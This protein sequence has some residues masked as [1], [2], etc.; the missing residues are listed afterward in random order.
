MG[1]TDPFLVFRTT[2]F[3][4]VAVYTVLTTTGTIWRLV[5]VLRGDDPRKRLLRTYLGYQLATVR[6]RP[7]SGELVQ[8]GIWV[9]VLAV[10]WYLHR[11]V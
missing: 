11:L 4:G 10:L 2:L 5:A 9:F 6:L 8:L 3:V 7:L 1:A